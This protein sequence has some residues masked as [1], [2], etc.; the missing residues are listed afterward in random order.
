MSSMG[1]NIAGGIFQAQFAGGEAAKRV[2]AQRNKRAHDSREMARLAD[3]QQ[4]EVE[5]TDETENVRVRR[6]DEGPSQ[7]Q[8]TADGSACK[9]K[10]GEDEAQRP[11]DADLETQQP[12]QPA[13]EGGHIDLSA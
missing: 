5:D 3:Q 1:P 9:R 6:A 4:H 13:G 8:D 11:D 10:E 12:P 7:N 2:D